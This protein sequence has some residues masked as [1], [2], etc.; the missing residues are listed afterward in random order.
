MMYILEN[1][2]NEYQ[3]ADRVVGEV[4]GKSDQCIDDTYLTLRVYKL[5]K[6]GKLSC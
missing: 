4:M 6:Q 2:S 1:T 3:K 5:I